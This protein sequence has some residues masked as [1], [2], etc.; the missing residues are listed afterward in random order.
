MPKRISL[1][2]RMAFMHLHD[3]EELIDS[4]EEGEIVGEEEYFEETK[5]NVESK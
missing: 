3:S 2:D 1:I 4:P 5:H